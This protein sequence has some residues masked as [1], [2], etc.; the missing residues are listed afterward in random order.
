MDKWIET[1]HLY[2][3]NFIGSLLLFTLFV[4]NGTALVTSLKIQVFLEKIGSHFGKIG[5]SDTIKWF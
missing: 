2:I 4:S 1:G 5:A 3:C